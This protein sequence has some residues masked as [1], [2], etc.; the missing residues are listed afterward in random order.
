MNSRAVDFM[1]RAYFGNLG[2]MFLQATDIG[3]SKG[4]NPL[5][6]AKASGLTSE[7][8]VYAAKGVQ[9]VLDYA[10]GE[11]ISTQNRKLKVLANAIESYFQA[12]PDKKM[13]AANKVYDIADKIKAGYSERGA[14]YFGQRKKTPSPQ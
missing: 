13:D 7:T 8:P 4:G 5:T 3:R 2:A 14:A 12:D 11:G 1:T 9:E 6:V 10:A